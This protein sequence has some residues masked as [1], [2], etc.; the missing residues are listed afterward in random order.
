MFNLRAISIKHRINF[1]ILL[2]L[3]GTILLAGISFYF[4][5]S[6]TGLSVN[7]TL[8]TAEDGQKEKIKIAT[9]SLAVALGAAV[10]NL[11]ETDKIP[12]MKNLTKDIRFEDDK[13]GY[14]FIYEKTTAISVP[15]KTSNE[16]KDLAEVKDSDGVPFVA[17]LYKAASQGGGFV[18]WRF[19]KSA[20][21][22]EP[23]PKLGYATMIPGTQCWIG[24][25]VYVDNLNSL[26]EGLQSQL[27]DVQ[28][29][30]FI[31]IGALALLMFGVLFIFGL[32][33]AKSINAP[34]RSTLAASKAIANGNMAVQLDTHFNDET[35]QLE[36][37]LQ[38]MA[39]I[40]RENM[41]QLNLK[42]KEAE[43]KTKEAENSMLEME[44]NRAALLEVNQRIVAAAQEAQNISQK[45]KDKYQALAGVLTDAVSAAEHQDAASEQSKAAIDDMC[46]SAAHM[47]ESSSKTMEDTRIMRSEAQEG[48]EVLHSAID[49]M[50]KAGQAVQ[51]LN[52]DMQQLE[53]H[54]A[55]IT[56]VITLIQDIADQTNLLA[57]N[58]AIEAARAGESGRGFAVV[59]DEVRKLA[60]KTMGATR[61]VADSVA[62]IQDGVQKSLG[63][64]SNVRELSD[65][66]NSRSERSEEALSLIVDKID[67]TAAD[68]NIISEMATQQAQF[69][70]RLMQSIAT[71]RELS[72]RTA[73]DMNKAASEVEE[74]SG[75][76]AQL[77]KLIDEIA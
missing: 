75:M 20:D 2:S 47:A 10:S 7:V 31:V 1:L 53:Q 24:T 16:G 61:D 8:S 71:I 12:A 73:S 67:Q 52:E 22:P 33:I 50:R 36:Q 44:K 57:L 15:V 34:L 4:L 76:S 46:D 26:K 13:S 18:L 17:E 51:Q 38:A 25:G 37:S 35:G 56:A 74:L 48:S 32:R 72:E 54:T 55:G 41:E 58:A 65:E 5:N 69:T 40:L 62:A 49:C 6:A 68:V 30:S 27:G 9:D 45:Q 29:Q 39:V 28:E 42:T 63:V 77:R 23:Q 43:D 11:P 59:A 70:S 21:A 66:S 3:L 19:P 64:M 14:Y 60:E